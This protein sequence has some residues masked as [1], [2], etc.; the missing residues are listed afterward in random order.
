VKAVRK[1]RWLLLLAGLL[2]C[3][4]E[5]MA[6]D[7]VLVANKDVQVSAIRDSDL[8]AIFLGSKTRLAD[9]THVVP[10]TLKGGPAHEVFLRNHVGETPEDFRALWRKAVFT[11]QGAMP[12]ACDSEAALIDYVAETPGAI[13][14]VSRITA[15][16]KD[17][18][19]SI[20]SLR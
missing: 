16:D 20:V 14:Y 11:G 2:A 3:W 10:I 15:Q 9:G 17:K 5:A 13:G 19:K 4:A 1:T 7:V 6:Q 12:K 8:R 18:V